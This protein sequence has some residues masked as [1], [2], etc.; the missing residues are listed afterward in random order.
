MKNNTLK[1]I[2]TLFSLLL[3][4]ISYLPSFA[5]NNLVEDLIDTV[6]SNS[7]DSTE[8]EDLEDEESN[9][10]FDIRIKSGAQSAF[11]GKVTYTVEITPYLDSPKTQILWNA[12]VALEITPKHKEFLSM[13]KGVTY[14]VKAKIEPKRGG[15]YPITV[16]AISWQH[17][18]NYTNSA[19]D[20]ITFDSGL[21]Q[22]PVSQSYIVGNVMK[23]VLTLLVAGGAIF[24]VIKIVKKYSPKAKKWFTPPD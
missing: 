9:H 1:L 3:L 22:Q 23:V 10:F 19:R 11:S 24:A 18:T 12:P 5:E 7:R 14:T 20:E 15:V 8:I 2:S 4:S 17:D 16:S 13:S 6:P 21:K